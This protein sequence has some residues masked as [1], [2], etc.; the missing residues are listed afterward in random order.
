[1]GATQPKVRDFTTR[2]RKPTVEVKASPG[3]ELLL[4]LFVW[5]GRDDAE[6]YEFSSTFFERVA[7]NANEELSTQLESFV[8]CGQLWL[9]LI[10]LFTD[11][12]APRNTDELIE[13][14][15]QMD[16]DQLRWLVVHSACGE[17]EDVP[18]ADRRAAA[19]G[20]DAALARMLAS[21]KLTPNRRQLLEDPP[22]I[23][24]LRLIGILRG[25]DEILGTSIE[26][27]MPALRRS[28]AETRSMAAS[29]DA[30]ALVERATNGVTFDSS[31]GLRGVL[32]IPSRIIRPWT[33]ISEREAIG[34]FAYSVADEHLNADPDTP[35]GYL[36]DLYKALGDER[37]LRMLSMLAEGDH[38]LTEI[39]DHVGLA[40][41]TT[42]HHLR[43]L[44]S[45]GLVRAFV[46]ENKRYSLRRERLPEVGNL[47][48]GYLD[49]ARQ[50][51]TP[52]EARS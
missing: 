23:T 35:P 45:A 32:L 38:D 44:R 24:R 29:L 5:G 39:A 22:E 12:K 43:I 8:G 14:V 30:P 31:Q 25:V 46:G 7:A 42:H 48:A 18:P 47:L 34:I 41:S 19:S 15:E 20:D 11:W 49:T 40:K 51:A 27:V 26:E 9:S 52:T 2:G 4:S 1:M 17:E 33:V 21:D 28:A 16:V 37:R 3:F 50:P 13:Q 10:E 36:V 6:Q